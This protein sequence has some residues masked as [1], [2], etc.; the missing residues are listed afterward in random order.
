MSSPDTITGPALKQFIRDA[1]GAQ[2]ADAL[3]TDQGMHLWGS[4]GCDAYL[5][6]DGSIGMDEY[7]DLQ[8]PSSR[9]AQ[10]NYRHRTHHPLGDS[11]APPATVELA[12]AIANPR[13]KTMP[14]VPWRKDP[15]PRRKSA[16]DVEL[17]RPFI[18]STSC[19]V[20]RVRWR[21]LRGLTRA[22]APSTRVE[23]TVRL[24]CLKKG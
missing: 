2:A 10:T 5:C 7:D 19:L 11:S 18:K 3:D 20:R 17:F 16:R 8:D 23:L 12:V 13:F 4:I 21:W 9:Q 22:R 24:L 1:L 6:S 14:S 15:R